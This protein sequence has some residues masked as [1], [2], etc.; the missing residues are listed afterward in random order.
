MCTWYLLPQFNVALLY[1][2]LHF[3]E[4]PGIYITLLR[5]TTGG[6]STINTWE[7]I[8][9]FWL[10]AQSWLNL[11]CM[12]LRKSHDMTTALLILPPKREPTHTAKHALGQT[13]QK[14]CPEYD[15]PRLGIKQ[16]DANKREWTAEQQRQQVG[17]RIHT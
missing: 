13:V 3:Y 5:S 10:L 9:A 16:T 2:L 7:G 4:V 14:S 12:P 6:V 11:R 8:C 15:G 1:F 17:M